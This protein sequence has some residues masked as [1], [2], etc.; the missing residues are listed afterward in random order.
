M[1][2]A[3]GR[4]ILVAADVSDEQAVQQMFDRIQNEYG[5]LDILV[6]NAGIQIAE[7]SHELSAANFDNVLAVNRI[8]SPPVTRRPAERP[9]MT[10]GLGGGVWVTTP[11]V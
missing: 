11:A 5:Q 2:E 7:D 6:N 10:R 8:V 1:A 4:P 9:L 3:G